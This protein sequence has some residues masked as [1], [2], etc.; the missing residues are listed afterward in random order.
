MERFELKDRY[1]LQDVVDIVRVLRDPDD[2]CPWDKE[3]THQSIRQN[4]LEEA[5]EAAEAIDRAD[6]ALLLEELGDVLLQ[7]AL[8][9]EIDRQ[10]GGFDIDDVADTLCQKLVLRH[11]HIFGTI[12]AESSAKVLDNWESIKRQEKAQKTG[13]DAIRDVPRAMPALMRSQKVQKRAGYVGFDYED[14]GQALGDLASELDELK[15]A[16]DS[17]TNIEEELGDLL[18]AA[19]NVARFA[20]IDAEQSLE[21]ACDKFT[22]RFAAVEDMAQTAGIDMRTAGMDTLDDLWRK[23]KKQVSNA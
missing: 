6:R 8:H 3:Q 22:A 19:V 12:N 7:V 23:A 1:T 14:I 20:H 4:F 9:A 18:F 13:L 10:G 15:A 21:K 17:G 2:G 5:Y 16:V 11:P